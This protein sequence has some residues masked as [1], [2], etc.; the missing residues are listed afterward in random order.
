[1]RLNQLQLADVS[2]SIPMSFFFL[3]SFF[4]LIDDNSVN[5]VR[6]FSDLGADLNK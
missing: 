1:M 5:S 6:A 4:G 2:V 3:I